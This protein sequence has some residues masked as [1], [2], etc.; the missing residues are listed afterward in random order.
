MFARVKRSG[1]H[2]Y[3]Q[4]VENRKE[5]GKVR[6]RVIATLG[7]LDEL[8]AKGQIEGLARSLAR[9]SEQVLL[10][11]SG[12]SAPG[13]EAVTIGPALIFERL[14]QRTGIRDV[15]QRLFLDR[16]FDFEVERAIFLAVLHRLMASG[17]DRFCGPWQDDYEVKWAQW[18]ELHRLYQAMAFLGR[19]LADQTGAKP[20]AP[21]S[22]KDLVE[23]ALF[24]RRRDLFSQPEM[25]FFYTTSIYLEGQGGSQ[26]GARG[27]SKDHRPDR[28]QMV[29]GVIIDETG[30]PIA[31]EMWPGNTTDVTTLVPVIEL[32]KQRFAIGHF[33]IVADRGTL[34]RKALMV[35]ETS[36]GTVD[37]ILGVRMR[38][39][40][41]MAHVLNRA[42]R[43]REITAETTLKVKEV[44]HEGTRYIV[45][46]NPRQVYKDAHDREAI[47]AL[48]KAQLRNGA[49]TIVGNKGYRR[50]LRIDKGAVRIDKKKVR[51]EARFDGKWVLRTNTAWSAEQVALKYKE[52]WRVKRI[53]RDV[54][55]LLDTGP[56]YHRSDE[57]MRGHVFA[58][59]LAL[60]LRKELDRCLEAAGE[61]F[62]WAEITKDLEALKWVIVKEGGKRFAIRSECQGVCGKIFQAV[63]V[64][65][66]PRLREL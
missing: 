31:C 42:G 58:S 23:E 17:S 34:S 39:A 51:A 8:Q 13:V 45:C 11:L 59:F 5:Q 54:K 1:K 28:M 24:R 65:L 35:M 38:Q 37:Y 6:Q 25:V 33:C 30:Q 41:A 56:V 14:W 12:K 46:L 29:V 55:T 43:W 4:L 19:P 64:A 40:R 53:F 7:R 63:G 15:L 60:V 22:T 3:L 10:I 9:L 27:F 52:L 48:L 18:C 20:F 61:R 57:T 47:L 32:L 44:R 36:G 21:R 50:Y 49:K 26:I 2:D 66:P 62:R 16:R